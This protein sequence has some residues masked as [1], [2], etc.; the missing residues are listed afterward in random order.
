MTMLVIFLLDF[1]EVSVVNVAAV[2]SLHAEALA[3]LENELEWRSRA[4]KL[5]APL[6]R[7]DNVIS[8]AIVR[9]LHERRQAAD[10]PGIQSGFPGAG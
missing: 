1:M 6:D 8:G 5:H 2:L 4:G 10:I 7:Y 9:T 3:L